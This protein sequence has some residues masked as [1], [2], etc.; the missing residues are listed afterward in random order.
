MNSRLKSSRKQNNQEKVWEVIPFANLPYGSNY[1]YSYSFS[2]SVQ[3]QPG[4]LVKIPFGSQEKEGIV[5]GP[6]KKFR[7]LKDI[8]KVIRQKIINLDEIEWVEL[9]ANIFLE[10]VPM[11]LKR[12]VS[13]RNPLNQEVDESKTKSRK[14]IGMNVYQKDDLEGFFKNLKEQNLILVPEKIIGK[15]IKKVL[16]KSKIPVYEFSQTSKISERRKILELLNSG[17]SVNI[18]STHSG[19]FLP[20]NKLNSIYIVEASLNSHKQW[21]LHPRYDA[22]IGAL[23]KCQKY[24]LPL[25]IQSSLPYLDLFHDTPPVFSAKVYYKDPLVT[26][27]IAPETEKEMRDVLKENKSVFLFNNTVGKENAFV[28][29]KCGNVLRCENCNTVLEKEDYFLKCPNCGKKSK[30]SSNFC[31]KCGSPNIV[32]LKIG[33]EGLEKYLAKIFP[34]IKINRLDRK[35]KIF[36]MNPLKEGQ[37]FIGTEKI[38]SF[39]NAPVFSLGV[40]VNADSLISSENYSATEEALKL[41]A[42]VRSLLKKDRKEALIVQTSN[43]SFSLFLK[44]KNGSLKKWLEEELNDRKILG[45]P[46]SNPLYVFTKTYKTEKE[47]SKDLEKQIKILSR[48]NIKFLYRLDKTKKLFRS[49]ILVKE[50]PPAAAVP[51]SWTLDSNISLS[52][53]EKF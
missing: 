13:V 5:L 28:C 52:S 30:L 50:K 32:P 36:D 26:F 33:T 49:G 9:M 11:L 12:L 40:I 16:E 41:I 22:R 53:F 39:I 35:T 20:F 38:F 29:K 44:L 51:K 34:K 14:K 47:A 37:I 46:P 43:P 10:P 1:K 24:G 18:I 27:P 42:R 48:N 7:F 23:L 31:D 45:Y 15:T 17:N 25:H 3:P 19:I 21:D 2:D 8:K 6:G 4:S